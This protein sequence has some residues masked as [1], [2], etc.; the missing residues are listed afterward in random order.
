MISDLFPPVRRRS[1]SAWFVALIPAQH[2]DERVAAMARALSRTV[3]EARQILRRATPTLLSFSTEERARQLLEQLRESGI[4]AV[5]FGQSTVDAIPDAIAIRA[6]QV[7]RADHGPYREGSLVLTTHDGNQLA[8]GTNELKLVVTGKLVERRFQTHITPVMGWD[9]PKVSSHTDEEYA[10]VEIMDIFAAH[11]PPLR[12]TD[13]GAQIDGVDPVN[14][15]TA[16][17]FAKLV[18]WLSDFAPVQRGYTGD[19]APRRAISAREAR[20]YSLASGTTIGET[21]GTAG[22]WDEWSAQMCTIH[23]LCE[24]QA[25]AAVA[26]R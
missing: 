8:I 24:A 20:L 13:R 21:T 22:G 2:P 5:C 16:K 4:G 6:V 10:D 18:A 25:R 1:G 3:Y 11:S 26:M 19:S 9:W 12:L 14:G 23:H 15:A 17:H 7:P